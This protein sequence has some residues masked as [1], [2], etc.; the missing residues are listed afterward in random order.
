VSNSRND[1]ADLFAGTAWYYARYRAPYPAVLFDRLVGAFGLD[2]R[3]RLL[4][5]G[6]GTGQIAL[7]L[8][9]RFEE[10]VGVDVSREML[11]EA[12]REAAA[13]GVSNVRWVE[14]AA[15]SISPALGRFRLVTLGSAFH[16]MDRHEV[17]RRGHALL[18]PGGGIAL[19]G[20]GSYWSSEAAWEQQIVHVVQRWLG[21]TRRAGS[22]TFRDPQERFEV[23]LARSAFTTIETGECRLTRTLDIDGVIGELY[24][25]SFC[26]PR[27]L[28]SNR[29]AF[30]EDLRAALLRMEPSGDFLQERTVEY[31]LGFT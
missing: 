12:R 27:L 20:I 1:A 17:L 3:G 11:A 31:V 24:S 14:M 26:N 10:V 7:P 21:S 25:T 23:I 16:W 30:E 13:A 4:D 29:Q 18:E 6:C 15:E 28:G 19:T 5:L 2:G 8:A 9:S 22:G